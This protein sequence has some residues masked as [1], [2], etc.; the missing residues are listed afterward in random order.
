[1]AKSVLLFGLLPWHTKNRG[2]DFTR[3][4]AIITPLIGIRRGAIKQNVHQGFLAVSTV[5]SRCRNPRS[6][7]SGPG[8]SAICP[9]FFGGVVLRTYVRLFWPG[10]FLAFASNFW[11][12]KNKNVH[13]RFLALTTPLL[14]CSRLGAF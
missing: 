2:N 4:Q 12:G 7:Q 10:N 11:A 6:R 5:R 14:G 8:S 9:N 3:F 1:M 13:L